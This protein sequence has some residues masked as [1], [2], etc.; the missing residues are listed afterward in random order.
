MPLSLRLRQHY[1]QLFI[2]LI[3]AFVYIAIQKKASQAALV[4][5]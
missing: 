1:V 2:C 4:F 3:A 5:R